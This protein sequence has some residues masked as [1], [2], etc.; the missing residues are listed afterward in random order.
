MEVAE[1]VPGVTVMYDD[2]Q[3]L[4]KRSEKLRKPCENNKGPDKP[5]LF[6]MGEFPLLF[7]LLQSSGTLRRKFTSNLRDSADLV[8]GCVVPLKELDFDGLDNVVRIEWAKAILT[9]F[10]NIYEASG[11]FEPL[12]D[13]I[14]YFDVYN[15]FTSHLTGVYINI[16]ARETL[17]ECLP[18]LPEYGKPID[19]KEW[20]RDCNQC[21]PDV[22]KTP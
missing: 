1:R 13:D 6:P 3:K 18:M 14:K 7:V 21:P 22:I 20:V 16:T 19:P 5:D 12:P 4:N 10:L 2:W 17:G 15:L 8:I 11:M 9:R